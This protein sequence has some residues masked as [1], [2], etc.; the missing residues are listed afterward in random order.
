[1]SCPVLSLS[2]S[3][4]IFTFSRSSFLA[5]SLSSFPLYRSSRSRSP[6][7]LTLCRGGGSCRRQGKF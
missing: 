4:L 5:L 7:A 6:L 1:M 3:L 2:L